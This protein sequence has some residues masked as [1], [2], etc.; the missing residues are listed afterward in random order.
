MKRADDGRGDELTS[1]EPKDQPL[2]ASLPPRVHQH[3]AAD[4]NGR[5]KSVWVIA[6]AQE[7]WTRR[8]AGEMGISE[9]NLDSFLPCLLA[10]QSGSG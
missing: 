10:A 5:V 1:V 7:L 3:E 4:H 9:L 2:L 6:E 8:G